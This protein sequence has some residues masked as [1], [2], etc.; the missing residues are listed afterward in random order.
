MPNVKRLLI[1]IVLAFVL[2]GGLFAYNKYF[3]ASDEQAD[4]GAVQQRGVKLPEPDPY[5]NVGK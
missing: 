4:S 3:K 2:V 5:A 1:P